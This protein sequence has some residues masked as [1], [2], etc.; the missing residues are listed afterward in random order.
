MPDLPV[1]SVVTPPV[2]TDPDRI[3]IG[4]VSYSGRV[5]SLTHHREGSLT[6]DRATITRLLEG[7]FLVRVAST[8]V[9]DLFTVMWRMTPQRLFTSPGLNHPPADTT[10]ILWVP[11]SVTCP[12]LCLCN[13]Q[14]GRLRV[15]DAIGHLRGLFVFDKKAVLFHFNALFACK[16][17]CTT[18][19]AE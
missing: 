13:T 18:Q 8:A 3:R 6:L 15:H 2:Y 14:E 7:D 17:T 16:A 10:L 5:L 9:F 11:T 4:G 1:P 12:L 19:C